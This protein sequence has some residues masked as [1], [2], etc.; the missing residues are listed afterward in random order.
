MKVGD[1]PIDFPIDTTIVIATFNS[2]KLLRRVLDS[3]KEQDFNQ[4]QIEILIVDGGSSDNTL[5]LAQSYG[6]SIIPN[7]ETEPVNAKFLGLKTAKG[8]YLVFLDHDEVIKDKGSLRRKREVFD[9]E[10]EVHAVIGSGYINPDPKNIVNEYIN[11]FGDPFS[12]F[13]YR[14]SKGADFFVQLLRR[15]YPIRQETDSYLIVD[16]NDLDRLPIIELVALGSMIDKEHFFEAYP[17]VLFDKTQIGHLFYHLVEK[18]PLIGVTKAD[19]LVHYSAESIGKYL[20]KIRW[21]VK[22]NIYFTSGT[23]AAGYT[24]RQCFEQ[25]GLS[26]I[27]KYLFPLYAFT[28]LPAIF[29][30]IDL[31]ITRKKWRYIIHLPLSVYTAWNIV[32]H[33]VLYSFG[34]R[35]VQRS[36]D[37][38]KRIE[39]SIKGSLDGNN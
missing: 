21:R 36:Y 19:A 17:E 37:E 16:F 2:E 22:N 26:R 3:I 23:G 28:L 1:M 14:L 25:R 10:P 13:M 30:A 33:R 11:E 5:A 6:C 24:G 29:D 35:P 8:R 7:P 34:Y 39:P 4:A 38:T 9:L 27:K 20:A 15:R 18:K 32:M 31:A 12:F